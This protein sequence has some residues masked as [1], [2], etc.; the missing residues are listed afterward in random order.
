MSTLTT[1][2]DIGMYSQ[3]HLVAFLV[4]VKWSAVVLIVK[5]P[6]LRNFCQGELL[7]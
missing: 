7:E 6:A 1:F 3:A 5:L 4:C 2:I